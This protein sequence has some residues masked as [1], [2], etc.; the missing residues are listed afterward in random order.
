MRAF[1]SFLNRIYTIPALILAVIVFVCFITYFLPMQKAA[2]AQYSEEAGSVGLS[3]FPMPDTVY[4]WAEAYGPKG[5]R[6]FIKTWLTYDFFWPLSFTTLYL[7]FIGI[8]MRSRSSR[9][10]RTGATPRS[11]RGNPPSK[12]PGPAPSSPR[13]P[14]CHALAAMPGCMPSSR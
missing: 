3:F 13:W 14:T 6:A 9:A 1:Y 2:T 8:T 10:A 11:R 7:V 12:E 5:R 4:E